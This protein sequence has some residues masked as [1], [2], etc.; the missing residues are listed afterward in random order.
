MERSLA[1]AREAATRPSLDP[2][3]WVRV[4]TPKL[5]CGLP[6]EEPAASNPSTRQNGETLQNMGNYQVAI[7]PS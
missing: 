5:W 3:S 6:S 4:G 1:V 7:A 2:F